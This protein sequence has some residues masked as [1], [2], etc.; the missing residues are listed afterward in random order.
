MNSRLWVTA[1]VGVFLHSIP[2]H[3]AEPVKLTPPRIADASKYWAHKFPGITAD[4]A[5]VSFVDERRGFLLATSDPAA[6][7]M[8]KKF[9]GTNDG[10]HR[11]HVLSLP[12]ARSYYPTGISF[13]SRKVGWI[14]A[15]YHGGDDCPLYRTQDGGETWQLQRL[16][17]PAGYLG[18]YADSYPPVFIGKDRKRGYLPIKLVR[19]EPKPGHIAWVN[20]ESTDGGASWHLPASGIPSVPDE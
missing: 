13:Q 3:G 6:G 16:P 19:H 1:L 8:K 5:Y 20:Y 15:T 2:S 7:L 17:I 4:A 14:T 11:W 10:G 18:G 9:Y 12:S